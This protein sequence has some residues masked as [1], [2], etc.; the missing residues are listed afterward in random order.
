MTH[1]SLSLCL[2]RS[3]FLSLSLAL[4]SLLLYLSFSLSS[5]SLLSLFSL[6]SLSLLCFIFSLY[7][8]W[9]D[10]TRAYLGWN[11]FQACFL[12]QYCKWISNNPSKIW[13]NNTKILG[14]K[15]SK[16]WAK[17]CL[18]QFVFFGQ[19]VNLGKKSLGKMSSWAKCHI[20]H[21]VFGQN[22]TLGNI[23]LGILKSWAF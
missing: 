16:I 21:D 6:S 7:L 4:S 9:I 2:S 20:G 14:Q 17:C 12:L 5:L 3:F 13:I 23:S 19:I 10:I 18:G 11:S 15:S 22:V 8:Y 1:L